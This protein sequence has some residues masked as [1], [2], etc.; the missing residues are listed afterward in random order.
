MFARLKYFVLHDCTFQDIIGEHGGQLNDLRQTLDVLQLLQTQT[1]HDVT[2]QLDIL[3]N[4]SSDVTDTRDAINSLAK[5]KI[6]NR[7]S[8]SSASDVIESRE[9]IEQVAAITAAVA[10]SGF[11]SMSL[12]PVAGTS[13]SGLGVE[14]QD[15]PSRFTS[16]RRKVSQR[17]SQPLQTISPTPV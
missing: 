5:R 9:R 14:G 12:A 3:R 6:L 13:G 15:R 17:K 7:K 11:R 1:H 4:I 16:F 10:S 8:K 2:C